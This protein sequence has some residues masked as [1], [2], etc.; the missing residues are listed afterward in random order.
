MPAELETAQSEQRDQIAD[1]QAV[2]RG[3]EA[4]VERA[5]AGLQM[6]AKCLHIGNL[7]DQFPLIQFFDQRDAHSRVP[8]ASGQTR[9]A[10]LTKCTAAEVASR[11]QPG[12][13]DPYLQGVQRE[14]NQYT[15]QAGWQI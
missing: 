15:S 13:I 9:D 5:R 11:L 3:I 4:A 1:V 6:L 8:V 10:H 2:R 14:R 12:P 7:R